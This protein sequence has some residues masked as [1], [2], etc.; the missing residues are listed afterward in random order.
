M[1]YCYECLCV[2]WRLDFSLNTLYLKLQFQ[3]DDGDV[4]EC[5]RQSEKLVWSLPD[6]MKLFWVL[7][8][9]AEEIDLFENCSN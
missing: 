2:K 4:Y 3:G 6:E 7:Q 1:L 8:F 5:V 9:A